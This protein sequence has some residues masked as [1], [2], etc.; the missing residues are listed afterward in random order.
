MLKIALRDFYFSDES[1]QAVLVEPMASNTRA[2]IHGL[3]NG[4]AFAV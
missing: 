4:V 2:R 1:V 3:I